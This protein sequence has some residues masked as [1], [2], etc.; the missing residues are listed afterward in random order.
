MN[1]L[2]SSYIAGKFRDLQSRMR[3]TYIDALKSGYDLWKVASVGEG[4]VVF[5][6]DKYSSDLIM[7]YFSKWGEETPLI[8]I[9]EEFGTLHFPKGLE[10]DDY[11]LRIILDRL[12]GSREIAFDLRT[13]WI[14]TGAAIN[15]GEKT[16]LND[17]FVAM[18][19]SIPT[20]REYISEVLISEDGKKPIL[21]RFNILKNK[22]EE[23]L[24]LTPSKAKTIKYGKVS[25]VN[26]FPGAKKEIGEFEDKLFFKLFGPVKKNQA[27]AYNDQWICSAGQSY[28][29]ATGKYRFVADLRPL[30]ERILNK[31]D[32]KL[33]LCCKPYDICTKR[34]AVDAGCIITDEHG[35]DL[36]PRLDTVTNLTWAG[37][38]NK[39]IRNEVEPVLMEL[40]EEMKN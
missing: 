26:F 25:V 3:S 12:D 16:S 18:Q 32:E 20:T 30:T 1:K 23:V 31:R 6:I 8:L 2:S 13:A 11:K 36:N 7:D 38:A 10:Q 24:S 4:D 28:A 34:I 29:L 37:Y 9:D 33:G 39:N 22:V 14:L 17:I 5:K 27:L 40:I 21:E 19:T 35:N 15:K